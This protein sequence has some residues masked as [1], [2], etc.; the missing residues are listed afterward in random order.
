ME[1]C[2]PATTP[3]EVSKRLTSEDCPAKDKIDPETVR[4]YQQMVGSFM[5]L[6]SWT[7]PDIAFAVSQC[8]RFMSNPGP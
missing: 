2:N 6:N 4:N 3:M 8:A 5:Y 7:R 1:D